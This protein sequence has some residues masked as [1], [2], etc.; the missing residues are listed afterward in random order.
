MRKNGRGV[1][2]KVQSGGDW[3]AQ[4]LEGWG[5]ARLVLRHGAKSLLHQAD[6]CLHQSRVVYKRE[7]GLL[8]VGVVISWYPE[9]D[10][11]SCPAA[12]S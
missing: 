1:R 6:L 5:A 11:D 9:V 7:V 2:Q 4:L 10:E 8:T 3:F 12:D